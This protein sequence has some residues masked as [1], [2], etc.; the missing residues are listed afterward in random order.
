MKL[1]LAV[2]VL[3]KCSGVD[4]IFGLYAMFRYCCKVARCLSPKSF[5]CNIKLVLA[6]I[7]VFIQFSGVEAMFKC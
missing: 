7:V 1:F 5:T 3:M 2:L 6:G 4:A